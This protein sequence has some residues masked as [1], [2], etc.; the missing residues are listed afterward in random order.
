MFTS[1]WILIPAVI[2]AILALLYLVGGKSVHT[3]LVIPATPE[4]VWSVLMD[5]A[6]YEQ[7]NTVLL[8]IEGRLDKGEIVKYRFHQNEDNAYDIPSTV[9]NME[10][11]R[12]LNQAGG[13]M[14][15]LTYDHRY[16]LE[17]E[18]AGTRVTIHEDYRG[19][20]VPFWNPAPVEKAYKKLIEEL[21]NR[22]IEVYPS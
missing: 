22:V 4:Q 17:P 20:A 16:I 14:G 15:I 18:D 6:N 8:P 5:T 13:A 3:E 1:K 21:K 2:I 7:W 9:K 11:G 12:L 19:I 10:P